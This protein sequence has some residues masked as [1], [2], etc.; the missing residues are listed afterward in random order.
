[1][2]ARLSLDSSRHPSHVPAFLCPPPSLAPD[3]THLIVTLPVV[4]HHC[5]ERAH[6]NHTTR[7]PYNNLGEVWDD[8]P[9][10]T[11]RKARKRLGLPASPDVGHLA[12]L[13][14]SLRKEV[15]K[16]LGHTISSVAASTLN[17]A[18]LYKEDMLDAF[19]YVGLEYLSIPLRYDILYETSAAYAG[20]GYGFCREYKERK[21]CK[22]EQESMSP[23]VVMAV[24]YTRTALTVSL[25]VMQ[26]AYY[27]YEPERR[28]LVDFSLGYDARPKSSTNPRTPQTTTTITTEMEY[29]DMVR[30]KLE[31]IMIENPYYPRSGKV[32]LMGDCVGHE[33]FREVL[34]IALRNQMEEMPEIL[35]VDAEAVGAKGAAEFAKR[36]PWDP[37]KVEEY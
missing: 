20:Y 22:A 4:V 30:V 17:L 1:M 16:S 8:M 11:L 26:S 36:N 5:L 21:P 9:R 32:L 35:D 34:K 28:H 19:E 12:K 31:Q 7:P 10:Q 14:S 13:I 6:T 37:Y 24:L 15:E 33:I 29:W 25:S 3:P 2:L 23:E 18:A 27:L